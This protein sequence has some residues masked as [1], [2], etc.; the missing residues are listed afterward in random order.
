MYVLFIYFHLLM[1]VWQTLQP[2]VIATTLTIAC[3]LAVPFN[4]AYAGNK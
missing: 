1:S 3:V 2:E 4:I